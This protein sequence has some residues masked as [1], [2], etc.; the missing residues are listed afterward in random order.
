MSIRTYVDSDLPSIFDIYRHS[1]LDELTFED[2]VF[3]LLPLE[4]DEVRLRELMESDIYLYHEEDCI[5]GYGAIYGNEV[6]ALL[7][8][9]EFRGRGV[10]KSLLEFLLTLIQGQPCLYVARSNQPA[11]RL[12]QFYGFSVIDTFETT[13][14]QEPVMAQK[15][16]RTTPANLSSI[17]E[18][19]S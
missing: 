6:R 9:P 10:G 5:L 11:K 2:K 7:V 14:N 8:R 18:Q 3:R 16:V 4:E 12:Y 1:K 19:N 13:Y 15:M 17:G